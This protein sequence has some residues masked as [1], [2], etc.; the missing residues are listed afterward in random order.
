M[1]IKELLAS[2][3]AYDNDSNDTNITTSSRS[4]IASRPLCP[5][6]VIG[7]TRGIPSECVLDPVNLL[8][9][10]PLGQRVLA[11]SGSD[12]ETR[13]RGGDEKVW[14]RDKMAFWIVLA[15]MAMEADT[16]NSEDHDEA[17][18]KKRRLDEVSKKQRVADAYL[19]SLPREGPDPCSW[20]VTDRSRLLRGTPLFKQVENALWIVREEYHRVL[21]LLQKDHICKMQEQSLPPFDIDGRGLFPSVLWARS[22]HIS[23]SF[24]RSLIDEE[25]IWWVGEK[26]Y[27]PPASASASADQQHSEAEINK[28][29]TNGSKILNVTIGGFSPPV[30]KLQSSDLEPESS[31][32]PSSNANTRLPG[33][34]L[35]IML[36]LY[37]LLDHKPGH[38]V[39][40]ESEINAHNN[41]IRIR[42]RSVYSVAKGETIHNNY[43]DVKSNAELLST[44]GF[45]VEENLMDKVEGIVLGL[46]VPTLNEKRSE[47]TETEFTTKKKLQEARMEIIKEHNIPHRF[48]KDG[49]VLLLGPFSLGWKPP[50]AVDHTKEDN[51][52]HNPSESEGIIPQSLYQAL[53]LIGMEDPEEGP[54][55]SEDEIEMLK[56]VLTGKLNN[57]EQTSVMPQEDTVYHQR[58]KFVDAYKSNQKRLLRAALNELMP[59]EENDE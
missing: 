44:Y 10:H 27:V 40:W 59:T 14:L 12:D 16:S 43:G 49:A 45:A 55:V 4:I 1:S 56:E 6:Q 15:A 29:V 38:A 34:D 7:P 47:D 18:K 17:P 53:G 21:D 5:G 42:F 19:N 36:P 57:F 22:M 30:I 2:I 23:R 41:S 26:S 28:E 9:H 25:G 32:T 54:V 11:V 52:S 46:G 3:A 48:E 33:S 37:D 39:Q 58:Q 20:H 35:G 8:K 51:Y 31:P 13:S 50:D 24:P